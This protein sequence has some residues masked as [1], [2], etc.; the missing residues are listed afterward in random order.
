MEAIKVHYRTSHVVKNH[1]GPTKKSISSPIIHLINYCGKKMSYF[2][3]SELLSKI[4][5]T[6]HSG[7]VGVPSFLQKYHFM[8]QLECPVLK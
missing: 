7:S 8:Q 3:I 6:M 1:E 2:C 4:V 5:S